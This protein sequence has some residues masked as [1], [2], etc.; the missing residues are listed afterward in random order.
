MAIGP[1]PR[2]QLEIAPSALKQLSSLPRKIQQIPSR[3]NPLAF[4]HGKEPRP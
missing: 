2:Y 1:E 4:R 3:R